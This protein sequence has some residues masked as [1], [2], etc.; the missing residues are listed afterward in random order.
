[1]YRRRA[2]LDHRPM[3]MI[4]YTGNSPRYIAIAVP[5][6]MEW[7]PILS[8]EIPRHALPMAP[9]ALWSALITCRDVMCSTE[10]LDMYAEML[11]FDDVPG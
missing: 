4:V 11:V 7:V 1:M 3:S 9:T 8:L 2:L 10:P 6:L 5:D